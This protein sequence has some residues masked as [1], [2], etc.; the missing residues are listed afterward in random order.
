M[1]GHFN[2]VFSCYSSLF[3]F[4]MALSIKP[5]AKGDT[6]FLGKV[7]HTLFQQVAVTHPP[8]KMIVTSIP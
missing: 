3:V 7:S 4:W 1:I 6:A 8:K 2:F 5:G